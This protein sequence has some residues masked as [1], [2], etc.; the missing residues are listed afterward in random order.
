VRAGDGEDRDGPVPPC[1]VDAPRHVTREIG[2]VLG[3]RDVLVL[4]RVVE[5]DV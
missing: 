4:L 1:R 2:P 5:P 3:D